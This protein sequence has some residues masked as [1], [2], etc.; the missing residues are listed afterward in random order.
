M[1]II[2]F[3]RYI[4]QERP[5][6]VLSFLTPYNMMVLISTIGLPTKVVVSER[7]DPKRLLSGGRP[8]LWLRDLLYRRACGILTQTEYAKSC[9]GGKLASKTKV[10]YNPI[11]MSEEQVGEAIRSEKNKTL[12]TVGR[13]EPVKDQE[14]MIEA[15]DIFHKTHLDYRLK[16]YGEGPIRDE[17][18]NKVKSLSLQDCV[19][20]PG[21]TSQVWDKMVSADCFLLTS[22]AEGM[23]NAMIE[24]LCLGLPVV[25]TKVAGATDFIKNGVN[26]YLVDMKDIDTL[27]K[28]M[29]QIVDNAELKYNM[30][31]EAVKA[32]E[33]LRADKITKQ[34]VDYLMQML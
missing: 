1:R 22:L 29:C 9:Y 28:R 15:F 16:I 32:Y 6:L 12:I 34:W 5:D 13:L 26:G 19:E 21:T 17:L 7:T 18:E 33:E 23:S 27:A 10:I 20:L 24:A 8:M 25:S 4:K 3:R 30:G 2:S 11:M 14:T 31:K